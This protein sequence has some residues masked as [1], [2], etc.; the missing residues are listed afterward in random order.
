M[1]ALSAQCPQR[2]GEMTRQEHAIANTFVLDLLLQ[3]LEILA[4]GS[5]MEIVTELPVALH[6]EIRFASQNN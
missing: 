6:V 3:H 4:K 1:I 5:P 2:R